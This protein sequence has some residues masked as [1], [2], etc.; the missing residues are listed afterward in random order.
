ML[1]IH[2]W[3]PS[4]R[5]EKSPSKLSETTWKWQNIHSK[6]FFLLQE[7]KSTKQPVHTYKILTNRQ[8]DVEHV[9]MFFS[10]KSTPS[11]KDHTLLYTTVS[12]R[13]NAIIFNMKQ[14]KRAP[15]SHF[16]RGTTNYA[17]YIHIQLNCHQNTIDLQ[18]VL[19]SVG[20]SKWFTSLKTL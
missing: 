5:Q 19:W 11:K 7:T 15:I 6:Q 17:T 12:Y 4:I 20:Y 9:V 10:V 1:L 3:R 16:Y 2:F 8:T 13:E 14:F 18:C